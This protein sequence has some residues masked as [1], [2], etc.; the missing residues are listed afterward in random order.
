MEAAVLEELGPGVRVDTHIEPL[1]HSE[2][3]RD[4]TR[5]R[6][7]LVHTLRDLAL[8]QPAVV[9]CHDVLVTSVHGHLSV[10]AHVTGPEDLP[11]DQIHEA[12]RIIEREVRASFPEVGPV[13]IHFE[14]A[15]P[16]G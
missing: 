11:L 1:Q 15:N 2:P 6:A 14:P 13:L 9:G 12:S 5:E 8:Q 4:V 3:G 16:K 10:V 7:D